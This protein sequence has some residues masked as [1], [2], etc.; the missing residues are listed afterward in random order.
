M[1]KIVYETVDPLGGKTTASG[2][3]V[4]PQGM[5]AAKPL[6]VYQHGTIDLRR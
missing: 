4:L 1:R 2:V 3:L 5:A 6:L